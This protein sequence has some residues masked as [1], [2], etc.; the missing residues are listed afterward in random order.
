MTRIL[1]MKFLFFF[2][3]FIDLFEYN[4]KNMEIFRKSLNTWINS[5]NFNNKTIKVSRLLNYQFW[6]IHVISGVFHISINYLW[7][8]F[9]TSV[10]KSLSM[11][12]LTEIHAKCWKNSV[13]SVTTE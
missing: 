5:Q 13:L 1:K 10:W 4:E 11:S 3:L 2:Y 7:I 6:T 12:L 9:S 8:Q